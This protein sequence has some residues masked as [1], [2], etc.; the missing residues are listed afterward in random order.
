MH[1]S[2]NLAEWLVVIFTK[3]S[4]WLKSSLK[5][6]NSLK[7][8]VLCCVVWQFGI[9]ILGDPAACKRRKQYISSER[10]PPP[11]RLWR[12]V[13]GCQQSVRIGS[14]QAI[15]IDS[16]SHSTDNTHFLDTRS[17]LWNT[18]E[19]AACGRS[20]YTSLRVDLLFYVWVRDLTVPMHLGLN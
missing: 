9:G 17:C 12:N 13:P 3:L 2:W 7:V 10:Q 11:S 14:G 18:R 15:M 5:Q 6:V 16:C 1:H 19:L 20:A 8:R 4:C